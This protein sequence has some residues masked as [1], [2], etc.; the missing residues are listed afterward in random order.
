M[1][2]RTVR[3]AVRVLEE[4]AAEVVGP[5]S[6]RRGEIPYLVKPA[7]AVLI[8]RNEGAQRVQALEGLPQYENAPAPTRRGGGQQVAGTT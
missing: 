7:Y 1:T 2:R 8:G 5:Y 3:L 4:R 6:R